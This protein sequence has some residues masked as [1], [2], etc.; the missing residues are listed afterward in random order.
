MIPVSPTLSSLLLLPLAVAAFLLPGWLL[1][2]RLR[3]PAPE[4]TIFLGSAA[5][6]FLLVLSYVVVHVPLTRG[7]LL[8]GWTAL[9]LTLAWWAWRVPATGDQGEPMMC[10]PRGADWL[11][12]AAVA[13]GLLS[14]TLRAVL[15]PLSGFDN[16]FR[17]DYLARAMLAFGRLDFYP[18]VPF[19]K[20][21]AQP[22]GRHPNAV[23]D[24]HG[25]HVLFPRRVPVL[26]GDNGNGKRQGG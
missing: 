13:L 10:R 4:L 14:V 3:S 16:G 17:W 1:N 20:R 22:G 5:L 9:S 12:I 21:R 15:D 2:R 18:P 7:P 26:V 24:R 23:G 6:L 19:F 8:A 25:P 11:W